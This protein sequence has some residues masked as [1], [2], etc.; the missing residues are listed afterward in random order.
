MVHEIANRQAPLPYK[1]STK[2]EKR[3]MA[4]IAAKPQP[5]AIANCFGLA[6][7]MQKRC[8]Q[9]QDANAIRVGPHYL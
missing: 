3:D 7:F 2:K 9:T 6:M 5:R 4:K 8:G 1:Y